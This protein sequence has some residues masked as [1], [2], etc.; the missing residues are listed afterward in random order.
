LRT[1]NE[2]SYS[3]KYETLEAPARRKEDGRLLLFVFSFF[4][5]Y[6]DNLIILLFFYLDIEY[7]KYTGRS[8][9]VFIKK[10]EKLNSLE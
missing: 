4:I 7:I 8:S 9:S 3:I 6:F 1:T 5:K 2:R 10:K